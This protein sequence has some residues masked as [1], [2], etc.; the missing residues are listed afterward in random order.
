MQALVE[1]GVAASR[2]TAVG[3]GAEKP[4]ADNATIQGRSENRR[5]E[6]YVVAGEQV[7]G[8]AQEGSG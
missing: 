2:L 3:Q 8:D 7:A 1:R 5:V 4:I 6:I